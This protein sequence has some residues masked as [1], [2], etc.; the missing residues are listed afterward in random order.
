MPKC[1]KTQKCLFLNWPGIED[2]RG[3]EREKR[4][5]GPHGST[6]TSF[7]HFSLIVR[8]HPLF[9]SEVLGIILDTGNPALNKTDRP[10][11]SCSLCFSEKR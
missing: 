5:R 4:R 3:R 8:E 6:T 2:Y 1:L 10:L 11:P 7:L 9:I